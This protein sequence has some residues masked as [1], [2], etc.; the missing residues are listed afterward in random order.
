MTTAVRAEDKTMAPADFGLMATAAGVWGA[1]FLFTE[2]ALDAFEPS[3]ITLFRIGFG[4]AAIAVFFGSAR[5]RIPRS[6]WPRLAL[7]GLLWMAFPLSMFPIAQQWINSSVAGMLNS[8]MP[9]MTVLVG[10]AV[11]GARPRTVQLLGVLVG[12]VGI[13]LIGL[14]TASTDGTT[15]LG[16]GLVVLAVVSY[17][18][19]INLAVPLQQEF[20]SGPVLLHAQ[21]FALVFVLPLGLI[22]V[23]E[24]SFAWD[25]L[26]ANVALGAGGTGVAYFAMA[27]LAGSVGAVR[28]SV[29]T[30]LIPVVST[31]LGLLLLDETVAAWAILGTAVVLFG[32]WLT[33]RSGELVD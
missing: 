13:V 28:A 24:S 2:I 26:A 22:A 30:Y 9:I 11:F 1:S 15:A 5:A 19:A 3:L 31:A 12:L 25:A 21:L 7:L 4:A 23:P 27:S 14:P 17:G 6:V 8:G 32:A 16:V 33:T 20:G 10:T 29:V 18:F